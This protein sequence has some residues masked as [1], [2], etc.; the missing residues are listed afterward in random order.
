MTIYTLLWNG[1]SCQE[2]SQ[3]SYLRLDGLT[4][5]QRCETPQSVYHQKPARENA[6]LKGSTSVG[7][8]DEEYPRRL[9]GMGDR[10]LAGPGG[11]VDAT[12]MAGANLT[13]WRRACEGCPFS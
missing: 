9:T 10:E 4:P 2:L 3:F 13:H 12:P 1:L 11:C 7:Q 8:Q 5:I 6:G